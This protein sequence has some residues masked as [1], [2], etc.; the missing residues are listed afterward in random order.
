[1]I[2]KETFLFKYCVVLKHEKPAK[3]GRKVE[4]IS[5][6]QKAKTLRTFFKSISPKRR[7]IFCYPISENS[8]HVHNLL[9]ASRK[10]QVMIT[11]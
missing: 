1:M 11:S 9:E 4:G 10:R 7:F 2:K 3:S 8:Q 6:F 5:L